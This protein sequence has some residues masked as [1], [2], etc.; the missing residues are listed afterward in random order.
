MVIKVGAYHELA[1]I[2]SPEA[3]YGGEIGQVYVSVTPLW[4]CMEDKLAWDKSR[5]RKTSSG[6]GCNWSKDKGPPLN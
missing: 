1:P 4:S 5:C 2:V 6:D 3:L